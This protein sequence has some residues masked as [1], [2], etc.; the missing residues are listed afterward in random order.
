M[1]SKK[2][3][4]VNR[5]V[6]MSNPQYQIVSTAQSNPFY[7]VNK[8]M[9]IQ[10]DEIDKRLIEIEVH[11]SIKLSPQ[12]KAAIQ[13]FEKVLITELLTNMF[14]S[15]ENKNELSSIIKNSAAVGGEFFIKSFLNEKIIEAIPNMNLIK[16]DATKVAIDAAFNVLHGD[17]AACRKLAF[18]GAANHMLK[19]LTGVPLSISTSQQLFRDGTFG[20]HALISDFSERID[21]DMKV[22]F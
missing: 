19:S 21:L 6:K 5:T 14:S 4:V 8:T 2:K 1:C 13:I 17:V 10:L 7:S 9:L 15:R 20:G 12:T 3:K 11:K 22:S 16:A 18:L